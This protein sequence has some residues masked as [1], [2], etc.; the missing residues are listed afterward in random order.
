[1]M[2][3]RLQ[4]KQ[5]RHRMRRHYY[6]G[7]NA[8]KD[9][10]ISTPPS[11][12]NLDV[13]LGWPAKAVDSLS[14]RVNLEGF[15][16]PGHSIEDF[17]VDEIFRDNR[18]AVE[19]PQIHTSAF[20]HS[21]SFLATLR[22]DPAFG[23]PDVLIQSFNATQATGLWQPSTR[24]LGAALLVLNSDSTGP[25]RMVVIFPH[26]VY[27]IWKTGS[28]YGWEVSSIPNT[29]GFVPVEPVA[30]QPR[31]DRPFGQSRVSRAVMSL[32]DSAMR[33]VIRAE[34]GAEFFSAPQRYLLGA[35][36]DM[37]M[38]ENNNPTSGWSFLTNRLLAVPTNE[39]GEKP[40]IGQF[41]QI[42]MQPHSDQM[43]MWSQLF[44]SETSLPVGSLGIVQDNPSSAEAIHA[45]K[46]DLLILAESAMDGFSPAWVRSMQTAVQLREGLVTLPAELNKLSVRWRDPSTPSRAQ[47]T[48]ATMKLVAAGVIPATSEIAL[49]MVGLSQTDIERIISERQREAAPK[50]LD[51]ILNRT[52]QSDPEQ[53]VK[54]TAILKNKA[55]ALG[56][57]RRAG[58]TAEAAAKQ[59]GLEGLEFIPGNPITIKVPEDN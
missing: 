55:D 9:L 4:S 37:F 3:E 49:E 35:D 57:L 23:E 2:V 34:V 45:V 30:F 43:R 25:T 22:G 58:V 27:S 8:L 32:T 24:S 28:T 56:L 12:R 50:I 41:S 13:A 26:V 48:D 29:L 39:E 17:G 21:T 14:K 52:P 6:D 53:A 33:T 20:I 31:L 16:I 11:L 5:H 42:S 15:V 44:A 54:E 18:L 19:A 1:M 46:E 10:G 40:E 7:T 51:S 36:E 47:A 38:D 59:V